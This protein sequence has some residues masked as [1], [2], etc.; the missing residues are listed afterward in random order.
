MTNVIRGI[1]GL[2]TLVADDNRQMRVLIKSMLRAYGFKHVLEAGDGREALGLACSSHIDLMLV[3]WAMKPMDGTELTQEVRRYADVINPYCT[4]IMVS[5]HAG[6]A[7]VARARD[8]GVNSF[9]AKP[10]SAAALRAHLKFAF[11]DLRP[12][13]R[14]PGYLG[15][16]RRASRA[17]PY[18]GPKRRCA[19]RS[20]LR[21]RPTVEA[22]D[23]FYL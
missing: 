8:C 19:D 13:V 1:E 2:T 16:D 20:M 15:P 14:S 10:V 7:R 3:D 21:R 12:F 11:S 5:G 18:G 6:M 22:D 17:R 23:A 4:V 9:L